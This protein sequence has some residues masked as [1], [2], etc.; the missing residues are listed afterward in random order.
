MRELK[1][2]RVR[3][4]GPTQT[5]RKQDHDDARCRSG[6]GGPTD[7]MLAC[8]LS[9][10]SVPPLRWSGCPSRRAYR[11]LSALACPAEAGPKSVTSLSLRVM[12]ER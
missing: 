5:R 8:E 6:R 9:L 7:L 11:R 2:H 10:M 1:F 12:L 4:P 3:H